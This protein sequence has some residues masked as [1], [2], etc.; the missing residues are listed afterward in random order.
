MICALIPGAGP[1]GSSFR[2]LALSRVQ[3]FSTA[4]HSSG[5]SDSTAKRARVSSPRLWSWVA[6][7]SSA[8]GKFFALALAVAWKPAGVTAKRPGSEPTSLREI[9]RP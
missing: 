1:S 6:V 9:R 5:I 2:K 8:R 3:R 4:A 7:A